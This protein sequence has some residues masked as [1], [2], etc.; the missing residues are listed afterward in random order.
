[1]LHFD[2]VCVGNAKIDTFLTLH[3]ASEHFR[4]IKETNELAIKF[5]EKITVDKAELLLG[6]NAANVSV[7]ISR[8]GLNT[9]LVAEIGK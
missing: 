1:M 4:L 7:G 6:G 8:L 5:G 2:V 3:E 9:A